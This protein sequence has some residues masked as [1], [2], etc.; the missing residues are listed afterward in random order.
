[1][2]VYEYLALDADGRR[3]RGVA[4]SDSD[5]QVRRQLRDRGLVPLRVVQARA[6]RRGARTSGRNAGQPAPAAWLGPRLSAD[7]LALFTRLIGTLLQSGLP[8]DDALD[9]IAR[10]GDDEALRRI[11]LGV[12]A[13]VME[14]HSLAAGLAQ[15]P[16][17]FPPAYRATVG[18]GEQTRHLPLVLSRLADYVEQRQALQ[19]RIRIALIYPAVLTVTATL[20]VAALLVFV[21]PHVVKVFDHLDQSLPLITVWL[22]A[23]SEWF[24]AWAWLAL[25]VLLGGVW[26]ARV[27]LRRPGP[28]RHL[29]ALMLATPVLGKLIRET[30]SARLASTLGM[31]VAS[32]VEMVDALRIAAQAL[33]SV[34]MREAIEAAAERVREGEALAA[35]LGRSAHLPA[36][37]LHLVASGEG[38]GE[39]Q[40]M[41]DTAARAHDRQV[42][43]TLGV[44]LG[45]VEPALIL[46]MGA[47]IL[48][49]VLAILLP[50]FEIN[51]LV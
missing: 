32:G 25:L 28:Q 47:V 16:R 4:E 7:Q 35:A 15:F 3:Q 26:C 24:Q 40:Q 10:Q 37:L 48:A 9:A 34:P 38:S 22:I 44:L 46:I 6:R 33:T 50:I 30:N 51:R 11:V 36:L 5:R 39:L 27:L 41:L 23:T 2:A 31:L 12:R 42:Q 18:A 19:Q 1:M 13:R 29:H 21:V 49:I 14:G 17:V 20:V 45:L 8:L 43:T